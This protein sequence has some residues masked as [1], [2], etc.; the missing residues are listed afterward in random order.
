M[1]SAEDG[2][3]NCGGEG[4][5]GL[6]RSR[7]GSGDRTLGSRQQTALSNQGGK[8]ISG[9]GGVA[10]EEARAGEGKLDERRGC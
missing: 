8:S 4:R 1:T 10:S 3:K 5:P 7:E 2:R 6:G 9:E